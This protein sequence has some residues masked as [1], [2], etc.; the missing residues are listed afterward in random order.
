MAKPRNEK[1]G[2][3]KTGSETLGSAGEKSRMTLF[4]DDR[5]E[6]F[7][8]ILLSIVAVAAIVVMTT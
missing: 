3:E 6:D 1:I 7:G 8:A 5:Q 4:R 2:I